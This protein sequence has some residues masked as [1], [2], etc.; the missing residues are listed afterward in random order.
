[1]EIGFVVDLPR[2]DL[3][4]N[5]PAWARDLV[6][7]LELKDRSGAVVAENR[8]D[9]ASWRWA[10]SVGSGRMFVIAPIEIRDGSKHTSVSIQ[11]AS[12]HAT[13]FPAQLLI[14]GGGWAMQGR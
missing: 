8:T 13:S 7:T 10:G 9:L 2:T 1:M 12:P 3:V 14:A 11:M 4:P 5:T 6:I